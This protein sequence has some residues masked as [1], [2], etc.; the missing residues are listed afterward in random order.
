M[1]A[2]EWLRPIVE[3]M[4][5]DYCIAWQFSD[6]PS[7]YIEWTG[8]CCNGSQGVCRNVKEEIDATKQH[9]PQLCRDTYIK[10]SL[11]TKACEKL[12]KIPFHLPLYSGIHGEVAMS[13]QPAWIHDTLGTQVLIPFNGG[14]IELYTS[15]QVP[16]DEIMIE[17]LTTQFNTFSAQHIL[18]P[19]IEASPNVSYPWSENSSLVSVDSTQVSPTQSDVNQPINL[20]GYDISGEAKE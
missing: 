14:L 1:R 5:W 19:K 6:D 18:N 7:R 20:L 13:A 12:A 16:R 3:T 17:M 11:K 9:F 10:H 8:C 2:L 15:R 4:A